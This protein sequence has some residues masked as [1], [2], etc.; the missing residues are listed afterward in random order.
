[1]GHIWELLHS[2]AWFMA[3][4]EEQHRMSG[5]SMNQVITC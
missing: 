5:M 2:L 3:V 4:V 1:M